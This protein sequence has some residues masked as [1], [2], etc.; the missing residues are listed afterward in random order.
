M[1]FG[2]F[3]IFN[4]IAHHSD[5]SCFHGFGPCPLTARPVWL[6]VYLVYSI[7]MFASMQTVCNYNS[8]E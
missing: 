5:L 3:S 2:H 7:H 4:T 6:A 1:F 8:I